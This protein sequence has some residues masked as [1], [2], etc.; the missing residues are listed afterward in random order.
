MTVWHEIQLTHPEYRPA[1][2]A[3]VGKGILVIIGLP[4]QN[5]TMCLH[6]IKLPPQ[7]LPLNLNSSSQKVANAMRV[8]A[9]S[10]TM[11]VITTL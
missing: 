9:E 10:A 4:M 5:L 2:W 8:I 3:F 6:K 7:R 11:A 1:V